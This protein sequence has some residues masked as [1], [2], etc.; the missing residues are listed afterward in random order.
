M[1]HYLDLIYLLWNFTEIFLMSN[2]ANGVTKQCRPD[3]LSFS[4]SLIQVCTVCSALSV[5][6]FRF[7]TY[8]LT[9]RQNPF[10]LAGTLT[11]HCSIEFQLSPW[12]YKVHVTLFYPPSTPYSQLYVTPTDL[13]FPHL[14][15]EWKNRR[16]NSDYVQ[17]FNSNTKNQDI[18]Q[19]VMII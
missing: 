6:I 2:D 16:K 14:Y 3:R 19:L 17:H 11:H 10:Y 15:A 12:L 7:F 4:S 8:F 13:I 9:V 5:A 1:T 18:Q